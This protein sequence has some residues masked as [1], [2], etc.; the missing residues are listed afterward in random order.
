MAFSRNPALK[1]MVEQRIQ[2]WEL[3]HSWPPD[4]STP[5]LEKGADFV[6]TADNVGGADV[7]IANQVEK[8]LI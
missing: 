1:R 3:A 6:T 5:A 8:R 4:P 7:E 2:K